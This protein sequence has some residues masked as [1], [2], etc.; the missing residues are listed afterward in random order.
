MKGLFSQPNAYITSHLYESS[1]GSQ[2][3]CFCRRTTHRGDMVF[4]I[5][6]LC[7]FLFSIYI[8]I[9]FFF[10]M[11][12][13]IKNLIQ[14]VCYGLLRFFLSSLIFKKYIFRKLLPDDF[15]IS[16]SCFACADVQRGGDYG[17]PDLSAVLCSFSICICI[18]YLSSLI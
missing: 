3:F 18:H 9:Q 5:A 2:H 15:N 12:E 8:Y 1:I 11:N 16:H 4:L 10:Y 7:S 14:V 17:I 6:V 13:V